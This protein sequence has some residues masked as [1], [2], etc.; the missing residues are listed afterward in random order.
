MFTLTIDSSFSEVR[1]A[2]ELLYNY[3]TEYEISV[4]L[5]GQLELIL[6]E[7]LNNVVEHAY[8]EKPGHAINIVLTLEDGS[9]VISIADTGIPAPGSAIAEG[10]ELPDINDMPEGGWGLCLIQ[11][12]S[13]S[14]EYYRHTDH[15]QLILKKQTTI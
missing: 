14:I 8:L 6:V 3:C 12:L 4:D 7:A 15:N 5:Q 2:S 13:D 10:S 11:A 1:K 9:T